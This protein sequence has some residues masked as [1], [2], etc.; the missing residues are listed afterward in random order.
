MLLAVPYQPY[1]PFNS[2]TALNYD[3]QQSV[4]VNMTQYNNLVALVNLIPASEPY[5][6]FQNDMPEVLPRPL[7]LGL[8]PLTSTITNWQ[9]D[10]VQDADSNSFPLTTSSGQTA[11]VPIQ[12][13]LANPYSNPYQ[14]GFFDTG[15]NPSISMYTFVQSM[16][17]SGKY[18]LLGEAGGMLL[19]E[20]DYHG[21]LKYYRPYQTTVSASQL[22]INGSG[23]VLTP[24]L[25]R[26]NLTN[27]TTAWFGPYMTLS[28]GIYR[29]TYSMMVSNVSENNT[30]TLVTTILGGSTTLGDGFL[31]ITGANFTSPDSWENLSYQF[32]VN[33]TW[34]GIQFEGISASW[35][36][37][38]AIRSVAIAQIGLE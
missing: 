37:M 4:T 23:P 5:V 20:R 13:A 31:R 36:G 26:Y 1:G 6:L 10:S 32:T 22:Y 16:I 12:Y 24:V 9:S 8:T 28:P 15:P 34:A 19:L 33:N 27:L 14:N 7:P 35:Q 25:R 11:H 2:N 38:I 3:L 29:A 17:Q 21:P 18:G 30:M